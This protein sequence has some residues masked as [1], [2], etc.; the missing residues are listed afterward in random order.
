MRTP[1]QLR[2]GEVERRAGIRGAILHATELRF[3]GL[4]FRVRHVEWMDAGARLVLSDET[5]GRDNYHEAVAE[6]HRQHH[7]AA[8][9]SV[10]H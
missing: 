1:A 5:V 2:D 7:A 4:E 10:S 3:D 9:Q 8:D 6:L